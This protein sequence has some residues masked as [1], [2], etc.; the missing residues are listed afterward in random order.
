MATRNVKVENRAGVHM[1]PST[2][3]TK[4]SHEFKSEIFILYNNSKINARSV[5]GLLSMAAMYGAELTI[6][7]IGEDE[8]QALNAI[9]ALFIS[10]FA[11]D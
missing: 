1:R 4:T 7:A 10:K 11:E 2:L 9:E 6:E 8:E 3:I 5:M